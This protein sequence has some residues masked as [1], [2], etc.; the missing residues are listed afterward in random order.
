M[1][2]VS[3]VKRKRK[4]TMKLNGSGKNEK[5]FE[6]HFL[7]R[8]PK[9]EP[10]MQTR[11]GGETRHGIHSKKKNIFLSHFVGHPLLSAISFRCISSLDLQ[12]NIDSEKTPKSLLLMHHPH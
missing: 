2:T 6:G 9:E 12:E 10:E 7:F 5:R 11:E 8:K 4:V 3:V 1:E